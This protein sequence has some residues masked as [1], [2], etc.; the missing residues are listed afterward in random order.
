MK[1]D[2]SLDF[3]DLDLLVLLGWQ[4]KMNYYL[5]MSR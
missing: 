3:L 1:A 2:L 5:Q 4:L